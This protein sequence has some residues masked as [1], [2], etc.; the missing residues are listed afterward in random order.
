MIR[1]AQEMIENIVRNRENASFKP[2]I[3][4]QFPNGLF[5]TDKNLGC[6]VHHKITSQ[7]PV[8][9]HQFQLHVQLTLL[10][11]DKM[12]ALSELKSLANDN[13]ILPHKEQFLFDRI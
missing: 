4:P 6:A 12:L 11:D 7:G 10:Q 1:F 2:E 3:F 13:F 9:Y 5:W 8:Q